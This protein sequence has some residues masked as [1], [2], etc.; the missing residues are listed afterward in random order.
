[1]KY[2]I[3]LL[4][5]FCLC[6]SDAFSQELKITSD[7]IRTGTGISEIRYYEEDKLLFVHK[8]PGSISLSDNYVIVYDR[9]KE[10]QYHLP[11]NTWY[12]DESR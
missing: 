5:V 4:S 7:T 1:M 2:F 9:R 3:A 6:R 12:V 8:N 10:V 11:K